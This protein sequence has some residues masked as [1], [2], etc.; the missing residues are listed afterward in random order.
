LFGRADGSSV[1]WSFLLGGLVV[2]SLG[3]LVGI[4]AQNRGQ[5]KAT[6]DT[7][8]ATNNPGGR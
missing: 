7:A 6:L 2:G 4:Q 8:T 5:T 1:F 3:G